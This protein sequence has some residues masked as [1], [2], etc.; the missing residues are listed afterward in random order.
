M[1]T[2]AVHDPRRILAASAVGA[3][4]LGVGL[5]AAIAASPSPAA[6]VPTVAPSS[7]LDAPAPPLGCWVPG[8]LINEDNPATVALAACGR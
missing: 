1:P 3:A 5:A 7:A 8:D 4:L 2:T 6:S